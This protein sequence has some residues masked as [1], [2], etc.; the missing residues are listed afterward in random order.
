[1]WKN[2]IEPGKPRMKI[3]RTRIAC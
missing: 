3:W 1:M 2:I